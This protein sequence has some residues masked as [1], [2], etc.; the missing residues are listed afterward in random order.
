MEGMARYKTEI[1]KVTSAKYVLKSH[2][3][4]L[5]VLQVQGGWIVRLVHHSSDTS[6][7]HSGYNKQALIGYNIRVPGSGKE[8]SR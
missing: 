4:F 6:W 2:P 1:A 3:V 5:F 7:K 8:C